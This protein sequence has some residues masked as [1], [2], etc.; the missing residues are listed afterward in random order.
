MCDVGPF[1]FLLSGGVPPTHG[2]VSERL[3]GRLPGIS[4][5]GVRRGGEEAWGHAAAQGMPFYY[6]RTL[7]P[8]L[9]YPFCTLF[10]GVSRGRCETGV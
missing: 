6:P 7:D 10:D 3:F 9:I 8:S 5:A 4:M 1:I 2:P